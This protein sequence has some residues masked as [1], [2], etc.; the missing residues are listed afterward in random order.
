MKKI[1]LIILIPLSIAVLGIAVLFTCWLFSDED[2][3][4]VQ[5]IR[6][7]IEEE[8]EGNIFVISEIEKETDD[9]AKKYSKD[10]TLCYAQYK[11]FDKNAGEAVLEYGYSDMSTGYTTIVEI[12]IDIATKKTTYVNYKYGITKNL[13]YHGEGDREIED[14][15]SDAQQI[16]LEE[17]EK[18]DVYSDAEYATVDFYHWGVDVHFLD[19]NNRWLK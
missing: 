8:I 18:S 3:A 7:D 16:Y 11:F 1:L 2:F 5:K 6:Y 14:K 4:P 19:E 10:V 15:N 17:R 9:I 13:G 12:Y